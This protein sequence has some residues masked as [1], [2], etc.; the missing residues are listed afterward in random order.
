M[1]SLPGVLAYAV[2]LDEDSTTVTYDPRQTSPDR[3]AAALAQA[4][5]PAE[6]IVPVK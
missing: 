6:K 4:G 3:I 1:H 5:Y 2:N